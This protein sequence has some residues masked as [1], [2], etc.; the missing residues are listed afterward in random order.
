MIASFGGIEFN[1][2]GPENYADPG[3]RPCVSILVGRPR[4]TLVYQVG[5]S[6]LRA[7]VKASGSLDQLKGCRS[8]VGHELDLRFSRGRSLAALVTLGEARQ[9]TGVWHWTMEF[10]LTRGTADDPEGIKAK[11]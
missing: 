1:E 11:L 6:P 8:L 5:S 7:V 3:P 4:S 10:V 9:V 2:V